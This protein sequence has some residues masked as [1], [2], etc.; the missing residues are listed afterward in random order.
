M[1]HAG[2]SRP[3]PTR[4][5][6]LF[7]CGQA[8]ESSISFTT[9]TF[10]LYYLATVC[11]LPAYLAGLVLFISLGFDGLIDPYIGSLSDRWESKWG[12]RLPFMVVALPLGAISALALFALPTSLGTAALFAYALA[13]NIV[14][15]VSTSLYALPYSALS[16]EITN[17]YV[18]RSSVAAYRCLFAFVGSVV[19]IAPAFS[20]ILNTDAKMNSW[21]A[22]PLLGLLLAI[23]T[24]VFGVINLASIKSTALGIARQPVR[25]SQPQ[26]TFKQDIREIVQ[27]RSF[28]LLFGALILI[29]TSQA[30]FAALGLYA[31]KSL[32]RLQ[33]WGL[34]WPPLG[35]QAGLL[36]GIPA[37]A[38]LL[39][40]VEKRT[41]MIGSL[42]IM[43]AMT[44]IPPLLI[45]SGM[46]SGSHLARLVLAVSVTFVQGAG[47]SVAFIASQSMVA[48]SVD[49]HDA[50]FGT[51]REGLYFSSLIFGSKAGI[52][53]GGF[54][55]GI[56]LTV[57]GIGALKGSENASSLSDLGPFAL[58]WGPANAAVMLLAVPLLFGYRLNKREHEKTLA[59]IAQRKLVLDVT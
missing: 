10:L 2:Q 27:N 6:L 18:E 15:R 26:S 9:G 4:F 41:G 54:I 56:V 49:T 33:Q 29:L 57:S 43:V 37:G 44:A 22:Y 28:M 45:V 47:S 20:L 40:R 17:D 32:Y 12:R 38:W 34:Q 48:D 21:S 5:K 31:Y 39:R 35:L 23:V 59:I 42:I 8:V 53:L 52:A 1:D 30:S 16:A 11:G 13:L 58:L 51:R 36:L 55:S 24:I 14:L 50:M 7:G 3:L 19:C 25:E 46:F